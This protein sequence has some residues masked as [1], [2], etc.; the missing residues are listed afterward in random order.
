MMQVTGL[1]EVIKN[2][3]PSLQQNQES[4]NTSIALKPS[5]MP[6][7]ALE[8]SNHTKTP[9]D[10]MTGFLRDSGASLRHLQLMLSDCK[11]DEWLNACK[12]FLKVMEK[13]DAIVALVGNRG[14]GKTQMAHFA[15]KKSSQS[16]QPCLYVKAMDVFMHV[17]DGWD[18]G[19]TDKDS[20]RRFLAPSLLVVDELQVRKGSEWENGILSYIIDRRYDSLKA[21]VMI[22]NLVPKEF[23]E[24]VGPSISDRL[25]E[26]GGII[27]CNW[28]S[29]RSGQ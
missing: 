20:M 26:T 1:E 14:T 13:N 21:T 9:F 24:S 17:K 8:V 19:R 22:A 25:Y 3:K 23:L 27:E 28:K 5:R 29:F 10:A 16:N 15:L 6:V 18:S 11:G 12:K 4:T 2:L 7:D